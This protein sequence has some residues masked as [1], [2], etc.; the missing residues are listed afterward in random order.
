M[1]AVDTVF[2]SHASNDSG[3]STVLPWIAWLDIVIEVRQAVQE[4]RLGAGSRSTAERCLAAFRSLQDLSDED[5]D[6]TA[7]LL[8]DEI[9]MLHDLCATDKD[10]Q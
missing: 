8:V 7:P 9:A 4:L 5:W 6:G 10:L 2:I 1:L 3:M